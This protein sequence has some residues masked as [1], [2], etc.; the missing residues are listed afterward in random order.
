[1]TEFPKLLMVLGGILLFIGLFMQVVGRLPGDI[2]VKKGISPS[3][4]RLSHALSL[5]CF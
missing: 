4:F 1:M 5:V 3:S 2:V